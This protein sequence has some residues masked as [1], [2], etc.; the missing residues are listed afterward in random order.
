VLSRAQASLP[1]ARRAVVIGAGSFGSAIAVLLARAGVRTTLQTR[2]ERQAAELNESR[3]NEAYLSGVE[4]PASLRIE[5][6]SSGVSRADFVFLAVPST[7]LAA[8]IAG[9]Q[10]AGL[11]HRAAVVSLS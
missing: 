11:G 3:V 7:S 9:L 8:A 1:G 10:N 6:V 4:L 5:A 2:T